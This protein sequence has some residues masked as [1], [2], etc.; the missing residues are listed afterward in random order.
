MTKIRLPEHGSTPTEGP[1]TI[2][3]RAAFAMDRRRFLSLLGAGAAGVAASGMLPGHIRQAL[4]AGG[5]L[6]VSAPANP[7]SMDPMTGGSG[8]DHPSCTPCSTRWWNGNSKA[9]TPNPAWPA[10]GTS[11]IRRPW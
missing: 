9:S 8:Q 4:A 10:P 3:G 1:V 11:P 2:D 6:K 7:S 5:V